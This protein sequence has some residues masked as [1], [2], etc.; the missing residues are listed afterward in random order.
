MPEQAEGSKLQNGQPVAPQEPPSKKKNS[1]L[2]YGLSA[3]AILL[4]I[5][6]AYYLLSGSVA[7]QTTSNNFLNNLTNS[8]LNATQLNFMNDLK[9]GEAVVAVHVKYAL[10]NMTLMSNGTNGSVIIRMTQSVDSY[11]LGSNNKS[12]LLGA[13][14][15]LSPKT[16]KLLAQNLS[17]IYYYNTSVST[18]TCI[19]QTVNYSGLINSSLQCG[20]GDSGLSYLNAFPFRI[21]NVS[22]LGTLVTDANVTQK[23]P[24][25]IDGR[26]CD[27]FYFS[28]ETKANHLNNYSISEVCLDS[29][30]GTP[31]LINE[32]DVVSGIAYPGTVLTA[33]NFSTAVSISEFAIPQDYLKKAKP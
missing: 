1:R 29:Q 24:R 23:A 9:K 27:N 30:Y 14:A 21:A 8:S 26:S 11:R 15:Y 7:K 31:L 32:S 12:I 4:V 2:V 10:N 28:N 16:R 25:L 33:V 19:N 6:P 18:L 22:A 5:I 17:E 3:V 13:A 20:K